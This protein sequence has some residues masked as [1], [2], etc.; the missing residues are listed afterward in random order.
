MVFAGNREVQELVLERFP[1]AL[2]VLGRDPIAQREA[3]V[4]AF[5]EG[6]GRS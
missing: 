4:Q 1:E 6:E 3:A 5:Q 2:H